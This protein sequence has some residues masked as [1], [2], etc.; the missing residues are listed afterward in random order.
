MKKFWSLAL[1]LLLLIALS[2]CGQATADPAAVPAPS[3]NGVPASTEVP[4]TTTTVTPSTTGTPTVHTISRDR[5]V[6][7]A[8][9]A[10]GLTQEQVFDLDAE[11]DWE[12]KM[13]YWE[14][15]FETREYEYSYY[16]NADNGTVVRSDKEPND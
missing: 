2:A 12:R 7:I 15:D 1:V 10:A 11:L 13:L 8:L 5:A 3:D 4:T 16:I 6:A 14:V 9:Q